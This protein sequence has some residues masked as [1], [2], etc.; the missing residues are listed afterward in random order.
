MVHFNTILL[1]IDFLLIFLKELFLFVYI[2][3]DLSF[4]RV[5][6]FFDFYGSF[7]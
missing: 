5:L 7:L 6:D 2:L 4:L 3:F 1:I